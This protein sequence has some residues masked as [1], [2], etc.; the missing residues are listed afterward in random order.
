MISRA[1]SSIRALVLGSSRSS[2]GTISGGSP[3]IRGSP[4]TIVGEL[5]ER[6]QA[7][8]AVRLRDVARRSG[9]RCLASASSGH[10]AR[11]ARPRRAART[12]RRGCASRRS[13]AS[14]RGTA[15]ATARLI[16]LRCLASNPR[17]RPA[18]AKLATSRLTSHSN[19]PGSVSSKSLTLK[20][21]RRSGAA[22]TPKFERW[23]SPQ[24]CTCR[25]VRGVA[26]RS[27]AMS[28]GRA[29]VE[30]E[31]RDEHAPVA[32]RDELRRPASRPAPRAAR[33]GPAGRR[34]APSRACAERGTS[35]RA[36][37]P[38]AA[39]SAGVGCGTTAGALGAAARRRVL[40]G[41]ARERSRTG[42][43]C[44]ISANSV[45]PLGSHHP[46]RHACAA[47]HPIGMRTRSRRAPRWWAP[48]RERSGWR[49]RSCT[50][51]VE[52]SGIGRCDLVPDSDIS[53][54]RVLGSALAPLAG[55]SRNRPRSADPLP[56]MPAVPRPPSPRTHEQRITRGAI[57]EGAGRGTARKPE[58]GEAGVLAAGSRGPVRA[59][60]RAMPARTPRQST[61]GRS[62]QCIV[63]A[64]GAAF[65]TATA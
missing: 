38:R 22:K 39:R 54:Q 18:T 21:S 2:T 51:G 56:S 28:D 16:A 53:A 64:A 33:R 12:R 23:A 41:A 15:R 35:A 14:P 8:L 62:S 29:A 25:P 58:P 46:A 48:L 9:A 32:E 59:P 43:L 57:S 20:T 45:T 17:S 10:A 63:A 36:A 50:A 44:L 30:R 24:S 1:G 13:R 26:A 49:G 27:A 52:G 34:R 7:V 5:A 40:R 31:R 11:D 61:T 55:P 37:R 3:M 65:D 47:H 19:G 4:S 60:A 42:A 6:L